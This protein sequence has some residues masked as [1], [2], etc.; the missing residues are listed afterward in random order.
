MS[1]FEKNMKALLEKDK[2]LYE[3]ICEHR[4]EKDELIAEL[5]Q[6]KDGS[7]I[8]KVMVDNKDYYLN[9]Q[10]RPT[11]EAERFVKQYETVKDYSFFVC[12]GFGNGIVAGKLRKELEEHVIFLFYEPS[13]SIFQHTLENYDIAE[14]LLDKNIY[15]YVKGLNGERMEDALSALVSKSNY[16]LCIYDALPKYRQIFPEEDKWMEARY[17]YAVNFVQSII[18]TMKNFGKDICPNEIYNL[19]YLTNSNCEEE[20]KDIFPTELPVIIVAAGPSLEKNVQLLNKAKGKSFIIA[21]DTALRYLTEE[22]IKPD[23]AISVDPRKPIRLFEDERIHRVPLAISSSSSHEVASVM[24]KG[25]LIYVTAESPYYNS[26]YELAGHHIYVIPNGGSVATVAV[27]IAMNWGFKRIVLVGQD[28][29]FGTDKVHAGKDDVDLY[30]LE[31]KR[32]EIEGY[33]G[34]KVYTSWDFN[35]YRLWFEKIIRTNTDLEIINATEG[36]A[37]ILGAKQMPLEEVVNQYCNEEFDFE[38]TILKMQ[39]TFSQEQVKD[40]HKRISESE[41]NL[42]NMERMLKEGI[43]NSKEGMRIIERGEYSAGKIK[44]IH[45]RINKII[46]ESTAMDEIYFVDCM[47]AEEEEDV[48]GDIYEMAENEEQEYYR[49]LE[50]LQKYMT[51]LSSA[52]ADVKTMFEKLTDDMR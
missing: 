11:E 10:Y 50:K 33:Y 52:V 1:V 19:Q 9:S 40:I 29:A 39:P 12:F 42:N 15:I 26:L 37:K 22:G 17:R 3:L 5:E 6:A 16:R 45:K 38:K 7:N 41:H 36:G 46:D 25:K 4:Y 51:A 32:I 28:L 30:K 24:S 31:D 49:L 35:H 21:V 18:A 20:F 48:L 47:V 8:T 14:L 44:N 43:R 23:L 27:A 34:D 13:V 2:E